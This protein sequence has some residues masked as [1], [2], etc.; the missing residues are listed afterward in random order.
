M[1]TWSSFVGKSWYKNYERIVYRRCVYTRTVELMRR[2]ENFIVAAMRKK[3]KLNASK[4][5]R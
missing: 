3:Y 5:M 2:L 4:L 1:V